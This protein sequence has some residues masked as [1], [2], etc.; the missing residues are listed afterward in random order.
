MEPRRSP[1]SAPRPDSGPARAAEYPAGDPHTVQADI[2]TLRALAHPTRIRIREE[3]AVAGSATATVLAGRLG[4]SSGSTSYHLRQLARFGLVE[5]DPERPGSGRERWWRLPER[6]LHLNGFEYLRNPATR[7]VMNLVLDELH[8]GRAER[9][10]AWMD[11]SERNPAEAERWIRGAT[12]SD[13][14]LALDPEEAAELSAE[15]TEV[16]I[17]WRDRRKG[18]TTEPGSRYSP[19]EVQVNIFPYLDSVRAAPARPAAAAGPA[20]GAGGTRGDR[21]GN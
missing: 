15:L 1:A 18:R 17:R 3:L 11:A 5:D 10:R 14:L 19:V 7:E 21:E 12:D 8:R 4:E 2:A 13:W 9:F 16:L 6:G 20:G